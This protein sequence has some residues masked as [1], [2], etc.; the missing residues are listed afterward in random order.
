MNKIPVSERVKKLI[1]GWLKE[2]KKYKDIIDLVANEKESIGKSGITYI[3]QNSFSPEKK[4]TEQTEQKTEEKS[5]VIQTTEKN[6]KH[7]EEV[8]KTLYKPIPDKNLILELDKII[9]EKQKQIDA[10]KKTIIQAKNTILSD[11]EF[12]LLKSS[13]EVVFKSNHKRLKNNN[14]HGILN[15]LNTVK[16]IIEIIEKRGNYQ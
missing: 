6:R 11:L 1:I 3:K 12:S 9:Q 10:L 7:I 14:A 16:N 4:I 2:K 8:K 15:S 5:L 13:Y